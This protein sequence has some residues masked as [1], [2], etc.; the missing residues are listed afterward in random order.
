MRCINYGLTLPKFQPKIICKG[1][2]DLIKTEGVMLM[3]R[4]KVGIF[5]IQG[6]RNSKINTCS[7]NRTYFKL[8]QDFSHVHLIGKFQDDPIKNEQF[9][10]KI[11]SNIVCFFFNNQGDVTL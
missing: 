9:M 4:S 3:T 8:I 11:K 5:S 6:G 10:L 1:K 7:L 2:E